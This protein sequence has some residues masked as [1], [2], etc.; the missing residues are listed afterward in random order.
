MKS[1]VFSTKELPLSVEEFLAPH[2]DI[3]QWDGDYP[4]RP[5]Q[6]GDIFNDVEGIIGSNMRITEELLDLAPKLKIVSN[7]SVGYD[8]FDTKLMAQRHIMGTHTPYVLDDTVADL[9]MGMILGIARRIPE[10]NNY[11]KSGNWKASDFN[12]FFGYDIHGKTL[13]IIGL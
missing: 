2:C 8:N 4:I 3:I 13:G 12:E 1:K 9:A 6:A 7:R 10:L 5:D 11:V